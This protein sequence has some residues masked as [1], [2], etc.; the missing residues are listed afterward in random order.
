MSLESLLKANGID[1]DMMQAKAARDAAVASA[2][3]E[4]DG[5]IFDA[6]KESLL[7]MSGVVQDMEPG[8]TIEWVMA[9][10]HRETVTREQ[11]QEAKHK[12]RVGLT[13]VWVSPYK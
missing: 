6:D 1:T 8:E 4:V 3:V 7:I 13:S 5:L 11:L 9:D 12:A 10:N 2:T